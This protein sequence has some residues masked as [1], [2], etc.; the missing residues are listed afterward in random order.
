MSERQGE[1]SSRAICD[2]SA[3]SSVLGAMLMDP[4]AVDLAIEKLK[5]E[6]FYFQPH[7]ALFKAICVLREK[8][9]VI[10]PTTLSD[11]LKKDGKLEEIG[12]LQFIYDVAGS[13]PSAANVEAHARI[14]R[15]KH[16]LRRV[17]EVCTDVLLRT[18][19]PVEDVGE[20]LDSIESR[21]MEVGGEDEK[22]S[23]KASEIIIKVME[24][25]EE[26]AVKGGGIE[27]VKTG[28]VDLDKTIGGL[29]ETDLC[30]VAGYTS[31]GKTA[32]SLQVAL[33]A[34]R[35]MTQDQEQIPT[36]I[37]TLEMPATQIVQRLVANLSG[38]DLNAMK[39]ARFTDSQWEAMSRA[40]NEIYKLPLYIESVPGISL[41]ELRARARRIKRAEGIGLVIVDYLQ[42]VTAKGDGRQQEVAAVARGLQY[43][44]GELGVPVIALS[45]LNREA[46]KRT[47]PTPRLQ[48]LRESGE[49]EQ[50]AD[51][52]LFVY[53]PGKE[54][55]M[56]KDGLGNLMPI[57]EN[58]VELLL[59]KN[60]NGAT[61][62]SYANFYGPTQRFTT[63]SEQEEPL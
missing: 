26:R 59:E 51:Q 56:Q 3:E 4:A 25:L 11:R 44:A 33:N 8:Q 42:M 1:L 23:Y 38:V 37:F 12:G 48:D 52:V 20:V 2:L 21:V 16:K 46:I 50:A 27:G 15:E 63:K 49:I 30:I 41:L 40:A 45:Q 22:K 61:D 17:R 19:G 28:F 7:R 34:T 9:T 32:F 24:G 6:S 43:L 18:E 29:Q 5:A 35:V 31:H 54:R 53:R 10:D 13:V 60:R 58:E 62:R 36:V 47:D 39:W 14:V 57:P 55:Q